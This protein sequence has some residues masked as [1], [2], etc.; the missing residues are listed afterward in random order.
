MLNSGSVGWFAE[1]DPLRNGVES[2][3]G[4]YL[5]IASNAVDVETEPGAGVAEEFVHHDLAELAGGDLTGSRVQE[6]VTPDDVV[7]EIVRSRIQSG[8]DRIGPLVVAQGGDGLRERSS[9]RER[10]GDGDVVDDRVLRKLEER[11]LVQGRQRDAD[12]GSG[13]GHRRDEGDEPG[14]GIDASLDHR[15]AP[16]PEADSSGAGV[17]CWFTGSSCSRARQS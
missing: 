17:W 16:D 7:L 1:I 5:A 6:F 12:E 13:V 2:D 3:G 15:R 10:R 4:V 9:D 8:L 14:F 11:L